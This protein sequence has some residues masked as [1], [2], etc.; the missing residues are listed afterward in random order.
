VKRKRIRV[1]GPGASNSG[2]RICRVRFMGLNPV[3][4]SANSA[5]DCLAPFLPLQGDFPMSTY[6]LATT[7][8]TRFTFPAAD[9]HEALLLAR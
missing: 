6:F 8:G 5:P 7:D 2:R 3:R 1:N 4:N 9:E